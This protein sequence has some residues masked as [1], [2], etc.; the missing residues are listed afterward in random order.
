M[1]YYHGMKRLILFF[2]FIDDALET[3]EFGVK[4]ANTELIFFKV[5]FSGFIFFCDTGVVRLKDGQLAL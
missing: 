2:K 3:F 4:F 1:D 5:S